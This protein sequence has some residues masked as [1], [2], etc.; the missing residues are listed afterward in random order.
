MLRATGCLL[1]VGAIC[2]LSLAGPAVMEF[3]RLGEQ[4]A[5]KLPQ[6]SLLIMHDEARLAWQHYIPH[7]KSDV[8]E[9]IIIPRAA[10]RVSFTFRQVTL[11]LGERGSCQA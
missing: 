6:R 1:N 10:H 5:L 4:R 11:Q 3:R 7:R 2:S 9:S 8:V